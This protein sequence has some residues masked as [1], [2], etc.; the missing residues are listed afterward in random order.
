MS[1][2]TEH[3]LNDKQ[4]RGHCK[5]ALRVPTRKNDYKFVVNG[6]LIVDQ[7]CAG[8]ATNG[9]DSLNSVLLV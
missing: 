9:Y 5:A 4:D 7:K 2:V 6:V 1:P 8:W 3:K